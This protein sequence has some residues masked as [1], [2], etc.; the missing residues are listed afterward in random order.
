MYLFL[1]NS[2]R[3]GISTIN[4]RHA[5]A[6]HPGLDDYDATK[7]KSFITYLD[8]NNLYG[9]AM[10]Q[11]LPTGDLKF[12]S[13]DEI[14][15]LGID[16]IDDDTATGYILKVDLKYPSSLN[17]KRNDF[18]LAPE[19]L[20]ISPEM[21]SPHCKN[22]S[23]G[24]VLTENLVPNLYDKMKYVTHY[25]Q[26]TAIHRVPSFSQSAWMHDYIDLNTR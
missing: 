17:D 23:H 10:R 21:L 1:E 13:R 25:I 15:R 26:D 19:R 8:V 20:K 22:L 24:H 18:P 6:N 14:D 7:Q 3:G 11:P 2:I 4:C 16:S 12:L 5:R 9:Y